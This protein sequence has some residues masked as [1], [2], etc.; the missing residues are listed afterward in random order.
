MTRI[1][2]S[3]REQSLQIIE[4]ATDV[5][6]LWFPAVADACTVEIIG[7]PSM[8]SGERSRARCA[9]LSLCQ[10]S[11]IRA[12]GVRI[13]DC[14]YLD[15]TMAVQTP[16]LTNLHS[17][18]QLRA[19]AQNHHT[20]AQA[21]L[22][23]RIPVGGGGRVPGMRS[24]NDEGGGGGSRPGRPATASKTRQWS[25]PYCSSCVNCRPP[26]VERQWTAD[27]GFCHQPSSK[28]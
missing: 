12:A 2:V 26:P 1:R 22:R 15:D 6:C 27:C 5:V 24:G 11:V 9:R 19:Q 17:R 10:S 3:C 14:S 13:S 20:G 16:S 23:M 18:F 7:R 8:L 4:P 25:A 21:P 28:R